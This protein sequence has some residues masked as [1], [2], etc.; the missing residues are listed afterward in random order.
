V[1]REVA[2]A[3]LTLLRGSDR[4]ALATVVRVSGSVPQRPGA[5]LL[6][7]PDGS[8]IGTVG[9]GAIEQEVLAA[10]AR[11]REGAEA[12]L[13][14]REL[15]YDL[16]MCC[17]GR[18]EIF[19]EPI[20]GSARL[21]LCGA[22]HIAHALAPLVASLG[23]ALTVL[24]EREE[25]NNEARFPS[26]RRELC[27]AESFLRRE[28]LAAE[29]W[30]VIATHDHA[31]D[32]RLL[33]YALLGPRLAQR[34]DAPV[35]SAP[36]YVGLVGS[37]RKV[38]RILARIRERRGELD[39]TRLYA[40]IG[41]AL[42]AQGPEEIAVSIAAELVALR[43]GVAAPH[44]RVLD[45]ERALRALALPASARAPEGALPVSAPAPEGALRPRVRAEGS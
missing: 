34:P 15:G 17:G 5:R 6:L 31:L 7:L 41:L 44:M 2:D 24:D 29:D 14:S 3:L 35:F 13:L 26:A 9:G 18:M 23:F 1:Q 37:R 21:V 22:G 16:G 43:R 27:D 12:Q 36:R 33:E 30:L 20:A 8:T 19:I 10:L 28:P 40:P 4:G 45:D 42:N 32:E 39:L 11:C 38:L 25:Q